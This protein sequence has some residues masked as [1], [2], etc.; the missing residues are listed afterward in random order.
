MIRNLEK[1]REIAMGVYGKYVQPLSAEDK[2]NLEGDVCSA[3][4]GY[5]KALK[6][7]C[8]LID[9]GASICDIRAYITRQ[10]GAS[11]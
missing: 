9:E 3:F 4:D 11:A 5:E 10:L 8:K 6:E 2:R 7:V 1:R